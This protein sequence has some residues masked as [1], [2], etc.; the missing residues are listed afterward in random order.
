MQDHIHSDL[1]HT[2]IYHTLS[3]KISN[4]HEVLQSISDS[5]SSLASSASSSAMPRFFSGALQKA[6]VDL[7]LAVCFSASPKPLSSV[8]FANRKELIGNN[9][10]V[11]LPEKSVDWLTRC[12]PSNYYETVLSVKSFPDDWISLT[13]LQDRLEKASLA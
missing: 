12:P 8:A 13:R 1:V 5:L 4:L 2:P 3:T 11:R 9:Q 10:L 7:L 6:V